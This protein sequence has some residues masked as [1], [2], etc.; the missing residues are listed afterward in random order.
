MIAR[1]TGALG[2]PD[3]RAHRKRRPPW[4]H[5]DLV[6][7][8]DCTGNAA[9]LCSDVVLVR[10]RGAIPVAVQAACTD[11]GGRFGIDQHGRAFAPVNHPM[12]QEVDRASTDGRIGGGLALR[13]EVA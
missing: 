5:S 12:D 13:M 4:K 2:L 10:G 7:G 1:A 3:R 8:C 9:A 6:P 11:C